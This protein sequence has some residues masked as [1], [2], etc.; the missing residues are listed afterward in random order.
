[1]VNAPVS[2]VFNFWRNFENFPRFMENIESIQSTGEDLSH[3]KVEGAA[4]HNRRMGRQNDQ[5]AGKQEI[6][7]QS[8]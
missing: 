6:A 8:T 5:R 1:V 3:W 2:Q 4:R 7:W